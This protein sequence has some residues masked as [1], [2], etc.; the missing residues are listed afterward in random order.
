MGLVNGR[1][2]GVNRAGWTPQVKTWSNG[3]KSKAWRTPRHWGGDMSEREE[4]RV[5]ARAGGGASADCRATGSGWSD[6]SSVE[7]DVLRTESVSENTMDGDDQ[8][9][10][11]LD[12]ESNGD[13]DE[14]GVALSNHRENSGFGETEKI[15]KRPSTRKSTDLKLETKL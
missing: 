15:M 3:G 12:V 4:A 7:E 10:E 1:Q 13:V 14:R 11:V 5:G 6:G 9:S 8:S 2:G